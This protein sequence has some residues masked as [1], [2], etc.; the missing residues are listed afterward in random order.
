MFEQIGVKMCEKL[1]ASTILLRH[2]IRW[3]LKFLKEKR[4][5][6]GDGIDKVWSFNTALALSETVHVG[7]L[8][9]SVE[10]EPV[11]WKCEYFNLHSIH[12]HLANSLRN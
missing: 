12:Y 3:R 7:I 6:P 1:K 5:I 11:P 10:E 8:K 4:K 2:K 9:F